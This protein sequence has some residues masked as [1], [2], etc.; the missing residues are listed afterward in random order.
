MVGDKR[1]P[2]KFG[3]CGITEGL[4]LTVEAA[5]AGTKPH[6]PPAT[7]NRID[8]SGNWGAGDHD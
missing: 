8:N 2:V 1:S 7:A 6:E 4:G 5:A 3:S